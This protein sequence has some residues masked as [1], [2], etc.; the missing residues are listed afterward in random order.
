MGILIQNVF[1][2]CKKNNYGYIDKNKERL[3]VQALC[4]RNNRGNTPIY[5][6]VANRHIDATRYLLDR[7]VPIDIKNENGN[8]VLHRAF[9]N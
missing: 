1:N 9:M 2:A 6:A 3:N 7:G 8:T 4:T 5:I